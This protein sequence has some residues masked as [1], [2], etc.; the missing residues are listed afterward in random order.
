MTSVVSFGY[1]TLCCRSTYRWANPLYNEQG[2]Q[3]SGRAHLGDGG[4]VGNRFDCEHVGKRLDF[5]CGIGFLNFRMLVGFRRNECRWLGLLAA[6]AMA[7]TTMAQGR[8]VINGKLKVEGGGLEGCRMVV[9]KD[10]VK[11]RT[12]STDLNRFSLELE[13]ASNYVLSFEK[14]GFVTKKLSFN[15]QVP[16]AV[17]QGSFTPFQFVVSLFRQYDGMN[18]VVFNQPVGMIRY[19][20]K[21]AD[22]DYDT[23]YTKSIQSALDAAQAAV[24]VKQ[25][26]EAKAVADAAKQ[27][28][29]EEKEKAKADARAAKESEA[30]AKEEAK[31]KAKQDAEVKKAEQEKLA[32][33]PPPPKPPS[34]PPASK[35]KPAPSTPTPTPAPNPAPVVAKVVPRPSV[36]K[37]APKAVA[38]RIT[39][40]MEGGDLRKEQGPRSG[41]EASPVQA[42]KVREATEPKP[43]FEATAMYRTRKQDVIVEPN[44]VITVVRMQENDV[45]TEYRKVIRKYSGTFYFKDGRS[46]S[47][48]TYESEALAE[49]K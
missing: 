35:P 8:F 7:V 15:T 47:Q 37:P 2:K 26:E 43:K 24:E 14:E 40:P 10:G 25:Q 41:Q 33:A 44:Q 9:Y 45:V 27:K 5:H 16:A 39:P 38:A 28:E 46:C 48:R 32:Q 34:P 12:I 31:A 18:T 22:F 21:L 13:L 19:D 3:F 17:T 4:R 20:E 29:Q 42:A 30:R 36:P 6:L 49:N 23:D 1:A 11:H